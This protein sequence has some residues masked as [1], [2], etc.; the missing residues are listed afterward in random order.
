MSHLI[1]PILITH[2][3]SGNT[4]ACMKFHDPDDPDSDPADPRNLKATPFY[5]TYKFTG[6]NG[7]DEFSI[8][9]SCGTS[10]TVVLNSRN[11]NNLRYGVIYKVYVDDAL[12]T[13]R[14]LSF[15]LN[16]GVHEES[17][18]HAVTGGPCGTVVR[19]SIAIYRIESDDL[20]VVVNG[21]VTALT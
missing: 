17:F 5:R 8:G 9:V 4:L 16:D 14:N 18:T 15:P 7:G 21:A 2:T 20:A 13:E 1:Q 12:A 11:T 6:S 3:N 10:I 19:Y